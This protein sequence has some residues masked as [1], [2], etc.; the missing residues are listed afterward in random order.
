VNITENLGRVAQSLDTHHV[1]E[2]RLKSRS[3]VEVNPQTEVGVKRLLTYGETDRL[4]L[5]SG[6]HIFLSEITLQF[7]YAYK[8]YNKG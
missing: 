1:A 5:S 8:Q 2:Y 7:S 6:E 4:R 3:S